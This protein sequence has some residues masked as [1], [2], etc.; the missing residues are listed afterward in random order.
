MFISGNNLRKLINTLH[1]ELD[2]LYAWLQS[3]KLTLN[4][5]KTHYMVFHRAKHKNM[6]IKRCINNVPIQQVDNTQLL[7]LIINGD[8]NWSNH[9]NS[10]IAKG[11]GIICRAKSSSQNL[12]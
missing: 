3:N 4:L 1:I 10:K 11:I 5:L 8:L 7:E 9:I 6:D 12:H 2:K